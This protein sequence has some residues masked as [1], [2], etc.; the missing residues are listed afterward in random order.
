[1]TTTTKPPKR[2]PV[3][4]PPPP[5]EPPAS[6]SLDEMLARLFGDH[7]AGLLRLVA[8]H[9]GGADS[10]AFFQ[11]GPTGDG[12][13]SR[14]TWPGAQGV[15]T[16][17]KFSVRNADAE[18]RWSPLLHS[19]PSAGGPVRVPVLWARFP[20]RLVPHSHAPGFCTVDPVSETATLGRVAGITPAPTIAL[21]S[22]VAL[23]AF[24]ALNRPIT[25]TKAIAAFT[26][27]H[28]DAV[29]ATLVAEGVGA[30]I[31]RELQPSHARPRRPGRDAG[32]HSAMAPLRI[33]GALS[34]AAYAAVLD[35]LGARL[36]AEPEA[37]AAALGHRAAT[38]G[39][40]LGELEAA[41][42]ESQDARA[43]LRLAVLLGALL[44]FERPFLGQL[45]E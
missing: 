36:M 22:G 15:D 26:R 20:N 6:L 8:G 23:T 9:G 21:D 14:W 25:S 7:P 40:V 17:F 39:T 4:T 42:A 43:A 31:P 27:R 29:Q 2:T 1:V 38:L 3:T 11:H 12:L 34:D 24:W 28:G 32:A 16:P 18:T 37:L 44:E 33:P 35:R 19:H 5:A 13:G 45:L 41:V 10:E 30:R